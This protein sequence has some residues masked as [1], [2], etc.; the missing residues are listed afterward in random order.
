MSDKACPL[1]RK[2]TMLLVIYVVAFASEDGMS[3]LFLFSD[4]LSD[5]IE[6]AECSQN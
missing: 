6:S 4:S 1:C 5:M 2:S 3:A